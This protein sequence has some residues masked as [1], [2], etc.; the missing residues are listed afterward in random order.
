MSNLAFDLWLNT[1]RPIIKT[2]TDEYRFRLCRWA[3]SWDPHETERVLIK[4]RGKIDKSFWGYRLTVKGTWDTA[5]PNAEKRV[6]G[7][8]W[9]SSPNI[10]G[11]KALAE[12]TDARIVYYQVVAGGTFFEMYVVSEF[13]W[14]KRRA[15]GFDNGVL[16]LESRELIDSIV[17]TEEENV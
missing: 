6:I 7:G 2:D 16:E 8:S 4:P 1:P 17:T 9:P 11:K 14:M 15:S 5:I 3:H 12:L 13:D 10:S